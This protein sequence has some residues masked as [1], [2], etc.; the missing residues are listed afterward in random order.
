MASQQPISEPLNLQF[1]IDSI[2]ARVHTGL[3][4][5]DHV[6]FNQTWLN[7]VGL[8]LEDL[9]GWKWTAAIHPEDVSA[10]MEKWRVSLATGEPFE[11]EA[12]GRR[13][14][15]PCAPRP[16]PSAA[17]LPRCPNERMRSPSHQ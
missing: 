9:Q 3:P 14:P 2:P 4:N 8:S 6:Y 11:H 12:W 10:I 5:G 13:P 15:M 1:L 7:Y 17:I 16:A